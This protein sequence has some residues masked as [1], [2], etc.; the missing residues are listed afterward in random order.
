MQLKA[1]LAIGAGGLLAGAA[2]LTFA[3]Q[4]VW[5][6]CPI[7]ATTGIYCPGCGGQR[8]AHALL[9]GDFAAAW[10]YN[11]LLSLSPLIALV[12]WLGYRYKAPAWLRLTGLVVLLVGV[13]AYVLWRNQSPQV[14]Y[15]RN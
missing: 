12:M 2:Y 14:D 3:P 11:Q 13:F 8:W 10:H 7:Y 4:A 15:L 5:W 1:K 6:K 9:Q